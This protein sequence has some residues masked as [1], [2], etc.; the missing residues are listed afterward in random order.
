MQPVQE[1]QE[2][3]L[4]LWKEIILQYCMKSNQN[5]IVLDTFPYFRNESI[6]RQLNS[7]AI[8]SIALYLIKEGKY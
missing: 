4:K 2:K 5:Q 3:Q 7:D 1:T 6:D 8:R